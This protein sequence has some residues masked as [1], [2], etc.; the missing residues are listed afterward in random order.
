MLQLLD[1][2]NEL[3]CIIGGE[4]EPRDLNAL[5]KTNRHFAAVLTP[6]LNR[7]AI[8]ALPK[9]LL[10]AAHLGHVHL[11]KLLLDN[12]AD[13][14][15][16]SGCYGR[17][18]ALSLA[19]GGLH[20]DIVKILL[21]RGADVAAVDTL[22]RT[23]LHHAAGSPYI[24]SN[25]EKTMRLGAIVNLLLDNGANINA[26]GGQEQATALFSA[27]QQHHV[28]VVKLLL[29]RGADATIRDRRGNSPLDYTVRYR[30]YCC[31]EERVAQLGAVV[32]LLLDNG[33]DI[34]SQ[35]SVGDT[36]FFHAAKGSLM[37][38]KFLFN[39][40][41]RNGGPDITARNNEGQTVLHMAASRPQHHETIKLLL[42]QGVDISVS[43][44]RGK[45]A[46]HIFARYRGC[47][48]TGVLL[49]KSGVDLFA[50][51]LQGNTAL[52]IAVCHKRFQTVKLLLEHGAD[53]NALNNDD[54]TPLRMA[55]ARRCEGTA[56]LILE[57]RFYTDVKED[58]GEET[59]A[60]AVTGGNSGLVKLL[61]DMGVD[62]N[63]KHKRDYGCRLLHYAACRGYKEIVRLLLEAGVDTGF[64]D[65]K[66]DTVLHC[67][68][69]AGHPETVKLLLDNGAGAS[70]GFENSDGQTPLSLA[71]LYGHISTAELLGANF[72]AQKASGIESIR[73]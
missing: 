3:I 33:A 58:Y 59:L 72:D 55:V 41:T 47:K 65:V 53:V 40:E 28:A 36:P 20:L 52:H 15:A 61:L 69:R 71:V 6:L 25:E 45:T 17:T 49:I 7:G 34:N 8:R 22:H 38:T 10:E 21:K 12:G 43:D 13:V 31:D 64:V 23:A 56:R 5:L 32:K 62:Y 26:K 60:I 11:T 16:K 24:A 14:E 18:T 19:T 67:A 68:A 27:A 39:L 63:I 35:N 29:E 51:D 73:F 70:A 37:A 57:R 46:L 30:F 48:D 9:K 50:K 2:P 4:L 1:F 44:N 42:D 66:N 54:E